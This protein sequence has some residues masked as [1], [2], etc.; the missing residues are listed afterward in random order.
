[1]TKEELLASEEDYYFTLYLDDGTELEC[2][3]FT[4]VSAG[5][6]DYAVLLP[7]AGPDEDNGEVYLYRFIEHPDGDPEL[8]N[9]PDEEEAEIAADAFD[10][11]LDTLEFDEIPEENEE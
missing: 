6:R 9:I 3:L 8:E 7:L 2:S 11:Y 5:G 10:E 4:I 1:M